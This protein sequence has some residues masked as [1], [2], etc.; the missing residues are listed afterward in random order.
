MSVLTM[1]RWT[2]SRRGEYATQSLDRRMVRGGSGHLGGGGAHQGGA[3]LEGGSGHL[4]GGSG[5]FDGN[6]LSEHLTKHLGIK[7][8][9]FTKTCKQTLLLGC[10][11]NPPPGEHAGW[12]G[13]YT[14]CGYHS[15]SA[16]VQVRQSISELDQDG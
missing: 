13:N 4:G 12:Q 1:F 10:N 9:L 5:H 6:H 8:D 7:I 15:D 3:H 16:A 14:H 2:T 11:V